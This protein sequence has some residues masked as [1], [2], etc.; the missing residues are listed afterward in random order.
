MLDA[1]GCELVSQTSWDGPAFVLACC[2]D[3]LDEMV[4]GFFFILWCSVVG[5]V[6]CLRE[7]VKGVNE[8]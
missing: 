8:V 6:F 7:L 5:I 2:G 3:S 4:L 1:S